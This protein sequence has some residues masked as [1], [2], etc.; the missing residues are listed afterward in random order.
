ML[1]TRDVLLKTTGEAGDEA[2][3]REY[4]FDAVNRLPDDPGCEGIGFTPMARKARLAA[5]DPGGGVL[6][7]IIGHEVEEI[8]ER[9]QERWDDLVADGLAESWVRMDTDVDLGAYMG[10]RGPEVY[11]QLTILTSE[12]SE[13]VYREIDSSLDPVDEYPDEDR[14]SSFG[15][16]WWRLLHQLSIQQNYT[17]EEEIDAVTEIIRYA[18][19]NIARF[20]GPKRAESKADAVIES[21]EAVREGL[22]DAEVPS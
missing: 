18:L 16:G 3:I 17:Y 4:V 5:F 7:Q 12:L 6:I 21:L 1:E 19:Q 2:V 20:D 13:L 11:L 14:D 9:E 15:V 8:I 10:S 22:D